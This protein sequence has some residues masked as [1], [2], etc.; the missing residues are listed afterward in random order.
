[1]KII[2][3]GKIKKNTTIK[4]ENKLHSGSSKTLPISTYHKG[5]WIKLSN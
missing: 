3:E 5:K 4:P 1:M 2:G